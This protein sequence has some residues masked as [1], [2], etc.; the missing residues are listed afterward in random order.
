M[1]LQLSTKLNFELVHQHA[2]K[3][4]HVVYCQKKILLSAH[5]WFEGSAEGQGVGGAVWT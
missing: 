5:L 1:L 3:L 4:K 2:R